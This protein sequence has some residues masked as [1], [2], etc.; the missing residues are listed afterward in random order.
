MTETMAAPTGAAGVPQPE[1]PAPTA[2]VAT[3]L[4]RAVVAAAVAF[5]VALRLWFLFHVPVNSDEAIVGLMARGIEHGHFVAFYWGQPYGGGE[6]YVVALLFAL[7][8]QSALALALT[9]V[10]LWAVSSVLVWRIVR[11]LVATPELALLAG[12]LA[13]VGPDVALSNS[14]LEYG[15]RG[16]TL[17]CGLTALL[18]SLRVL[19]GRSPGSMPVRPRIGRRASAG[20][21]RPRSPTT[22]CRPG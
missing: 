19:D 6:P 15:F 3:W 4:V 14:T 16:V 7:F 8:G 2:P 9:P 21:R 17:V 12:A 22:R 18:M 13:W 5:G 1:E 20:G 10:L 11:R